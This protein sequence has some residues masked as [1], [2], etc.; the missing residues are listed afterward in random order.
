M[1]QSCWQR[2][3]YNSGAS[4]WKYNN[5]YV[6]EDDAYRHSKWLAM[7]ERRLKLAK[8]LLNPTNA[9]LI[10]TIDEKE[11]LRLGLL[12]EQIFP[13][14][15]MQMIS[16][17]INPKGTG[18]LNEFFEN[19]RVHL[20]C[21]SRGCR[22]AGSTRRRKRSRSPVALSPANGRRICQRHQ[23]RRAIS[24]LSD[25]RGQRQLQDR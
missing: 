17:V 5:D 9:V 21:A 2:G 3:P 4:D 19:G 22:C 11:Y 12:L 14:A 15:T 1:S 25:L 8:R 10:V 6:D 18:R 23:E 16:S 7:M 13:E 20:L 24:V